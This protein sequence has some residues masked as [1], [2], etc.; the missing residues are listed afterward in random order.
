[1]RILFTWGA[2]KVN[3]KGGA[4]KMKF[5]LVEWRRAKGITQDEMAKLLGISKPT[6]VR[7]EKTPE[8]ISMGFALKI[9]SIFET[10]LSSIIFLP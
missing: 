4:D 10:D 6:Y 3:M 2:S 9:A 5:K 1:M 7:W 8:N